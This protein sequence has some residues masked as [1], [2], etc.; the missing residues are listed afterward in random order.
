MPEST[1]ART[2]AKAT[3]FDS[4]GSRAKILDCDE[5][6]GSLVNQG[7]MPSNEPGAPEML[8][9]GDR[10]SPP[11]VNRPGGAARRRKRRVRRGHT[12]R[13]ALEPGPTGGSRSPTITAWTS[14]VSALGALG[15]PSRV[16]HDKPFEHDAARRVPAVDKAE[17]LLGFEAPSTLDETLYEVVAWIEKTAAEN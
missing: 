7:V 8:E 4:R 9:R 12:S 16:L 5:G 11:G 1:T 13:G 10:R 14:R 6:A 3:E 2:P 15:V 17:I